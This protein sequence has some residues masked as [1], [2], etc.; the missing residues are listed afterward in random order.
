VVATHGHGLPSLAE[1]DT[2]AR[3][4]DG[5]LVFQYRNRENWYDVHPLLWSQVEA[6]AGAVAP[7]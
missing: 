7:G 2:L 5:K 6:H 1:L 3:L 4:L